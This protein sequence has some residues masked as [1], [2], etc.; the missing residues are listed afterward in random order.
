MHE[1][2]QTAFPARLE[3][4]VARFDKDGLAVQPQRCALDQTIGKM[5]AGTVCTRLQRQFNFTFGQGADVAC[6]EARTEVTVGLQLIR[7][8]SG[9]GGMAGQIDG[10]GDDG[11]GRI[12]HGG[13]A[14]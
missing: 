4:N 9:D 13:I 7:R 2:F 12:C 8:H 10:I 1:D 3:F 5:P 6:N 11:G 14:G